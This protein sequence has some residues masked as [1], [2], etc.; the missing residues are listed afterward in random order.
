MRN[1][2]PGER[3]LNRGII[4]FIILIMAKDGPIYGS[5]VANKIYE[6]TDGTWKP[7]PGSIYPA[8]KHL[9]H[10]GFIQKYDEDGKVM[11]S[12]TK[13]GSVFTSKIT[14]RHSERMHMFR[15]MGRLWTEMMSPDEMTKFIISSTKNVTS[16]LNENLEKIKASMETPK[17]YE[18]FLMSCEIELEKALK[19]VRNERKEL[20]EI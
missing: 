11:Y 18:V 7:S 10:R 12:L 2:E 17:E 20:V 16:Y 1:M 13:K 4:F 6:K 19:L 8:L 15:M 14:E 5:Q 3:K 9:E